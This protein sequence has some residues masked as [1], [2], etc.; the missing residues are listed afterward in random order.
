LGEREDTGRKVPRP[1][2][3]KMRGLK[4][5]RMR[6]PRTR[7]RIGSKTK[8]KTRRLQSVARRVQSVSY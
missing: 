8:T 3:K 5:R 7:R 2:T 6:R 1:K 4:T